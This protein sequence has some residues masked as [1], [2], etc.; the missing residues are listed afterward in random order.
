M[1]TSG[2][3]IGTLFG[4]VFG[5][6]FVL[7]GW[8]AVLILLAFTVGGFAIGFALDG[9]PAILGGLRRFFDRLLHS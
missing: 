9:Q 7:L 6:L 2:K 3:A 5:L 1:P 4:L 8:K